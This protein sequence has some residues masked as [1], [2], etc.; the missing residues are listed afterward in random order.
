M[1]PSRPSAHLHCRPLED[2][3][4]PAVTAS[5]NGG[6]L[7]LTGDNTDNTVL[8]RQYRQHDGR[9][10]E[11][12]RSARSIQH[13]ACLPRGNGQIPLICTSPVQPRRSN[14]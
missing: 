13:P 4:T 7:V 2:R 6:A 14:G 5:L 12:R 8:I 1:S 3:N 11:R 10:R 9:G